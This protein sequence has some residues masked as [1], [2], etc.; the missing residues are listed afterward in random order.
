[1]AA[2][3]FTGNSATQTVNNS[4]NGTSF[5]PDLIWFKNRSNALE[6]AILDAVRGGTPPLFL[7][8]NSTAAEGSTGGGESITYNSNGFAV[9]SNNQRINFSG[10][11]YVAWQWNA[12]GSTVTNTSGTISAQVRANPTAGFSVVTY[13]GT[14]ANATVGHGL[15]VAPRMVIVKGRSFVSNWN[16]FHKSLFDINSAYTLALN[17]TTYPSGGGSPTIFNS[18]APTS[19][20]FSIGTSSD[21]NTNGATLVAYCFA[22]VAGYSAFGSYTG[23]GSADGPFVFT[24]FRPRFLMVKNSSAVGNWLMFDSS[25]DTYNQE[26]LFFF[27]NTSDAEQNSSGTVSFDFLS[28]GF[29]VRNTSGNI[30]G[31][32]NTLIYMA[33]A[34]NPFKTSRAR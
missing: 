17:S 11:T 15:G 12:G 1:M 9:I 20:V 29:K 33:F 32:G 16:V 23:N 34:E 22:P 2:S 28:N 8:S 30:N 24:G 7:S 27:A 3:L 18:T 6:H 19:S 14:G 10:Y 5:Q 25:R 26:V 13:T 31:S 4:T 21:I